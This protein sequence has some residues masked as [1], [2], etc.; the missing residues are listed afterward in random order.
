MAAQKEAIEKDYGEWRLIESRILVR[1]R[2]LF[3]QWASR[4][5]VIRTS[6]AYVFSDP[7]PQLAGVSAC[8]SENPTGTLNQDVLSRVCA[9]SRSRQPPRASPNPIRRS[10]RRQRMHRTRERAGRCHRIETKHV[11]TTIFRPLPEGADVRGCGV[12]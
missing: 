5:R 2:D 8:K 10:T 12:T 1:K 6:N 7:K 9:A 3:G 11:G 4:W